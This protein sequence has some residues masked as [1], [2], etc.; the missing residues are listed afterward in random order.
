MVDSSN[1]SPLAIETEATLRRNQ[2][3]IQRILKWLQQY[4]PFRIY[5]ELPYGRLSIEEQLCLRPKHAT[6]EW[7]KCA[8]ARDDVV[9]VLRIVAREM[10][11]PN[12]C[13]IPQDPLSVV[14]IP[15][16]DDYAV[17]HL[18]LGIRDAFDVDVSNILRAQCERRNEV[19]MQEFV[20]YVLKAHG[21][22][23]DTKC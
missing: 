15:G 6:A 22:P 23:R 2:K 1:Y 20:E 18:Q 9:S 17:E 8:F 11:W 7:D 16:F 13:F 19:T 4:C 12:W 3:K 5:A 21:E 10:H 14:I